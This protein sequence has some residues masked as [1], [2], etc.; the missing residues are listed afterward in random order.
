[1]TTEGARTGP[2][3]EYMVDSGIMNTCQM[4]IAHNVNNK[5]ETILLFMLS[6]ALL[7]QFQLR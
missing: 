1:M 3:S 7:G 4:P 5:P 2:I 6:Q